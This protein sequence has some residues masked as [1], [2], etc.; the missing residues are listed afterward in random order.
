[1]VKYRIFVEWKRFRLD[2]MVRTILLWHTKVF[3]FYSRL[4][5]TISSCRLRSR[6]LD[7]HLLHLPLFL[8]PLNQP[9]AQVCPHGSTQDWCHPPPFSSPTSILYQP[10]TYAFIGLAILSVYNKQG[11][12]DLAKGLVK[13]DIRLLAS[14]GTAKRQSSSSSRNF[15]HRHLDS[16]KNKS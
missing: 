6:A 4:T 13:H 9:W 12:L 11:L 8:F 5:S 1:M 15:H 3:K 7:F 14:G 2:W 16:L 10:L